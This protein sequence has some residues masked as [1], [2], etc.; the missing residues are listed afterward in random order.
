L[1]RPASAWDS[2]AAAPLSSY[3]LDLK[4]PATRATEGTTSKGR[5]W[6]GKDP[7]L[8][9]VEKENIFAKFLQNPPA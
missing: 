8:L 3:G 6:L 7:T 9:N 1:L 5:D 2:K 4:T